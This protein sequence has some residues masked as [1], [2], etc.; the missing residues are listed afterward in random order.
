VTVDVKPQLLVWARERAQLPIRAL[1]SR[2]PRLREWES[3]DAAPT[4][5]QLEKYARATYTPV[6]LFFLAEPPE[7]TLPIPD[8]RTAGDAVIARPSANLLDTIYECEQR[9]EWYRDTVR[10]SGAEPIVFVGSAST[11]D[12]PETAAAEIRATLL[13]SIEERRQQSTWGEALRALIARTEDLGIL[14]MVSGVVGNN[15]SR[16]LDPME[17]RGFALADDLAPLVFVNGADSKAA[18]MFTLMHEIA[19]LWLGTSSLDNVNPA[20]A[21]RGRVEDWCNE[22]AAEAL[23]PLATLRNEYRPQ[24]SL[25]DALSRLARHFKVS[26]LVV[27]RRLY[28][29]G[30][31]SK[32]NYWDAYEKELEKTQ[33][34][35]AASGG[36]FYATQASRVGRRFATTLVASTL[37]GRT[38]YRDALRLLGISKVSTFQDF[39]RSLGFDMVA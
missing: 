9:Q 37:E 11:N 15:T 32:A 14:V 3:G 18:Q 39:G 2:F 17:F 26:T 19:H 25:D 10:A 36:N 7:E 29:A 8:F 23:V 4:L 5:K 31:L 6:G 22:V 28:A 30:I 13:C 34:R 16:K 35:A 33:A 24:E 1:E 27:L 21:E 12:L 20:P 38:L